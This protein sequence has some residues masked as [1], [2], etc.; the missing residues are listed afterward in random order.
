MTLKVTHE[1]LD[2]CTEI[3]RHSDHVV[4]LDPDLRTVE[5]I[6]DGDPRLAIYAELNRPLKG[7]RSI[8]VEAATLRV[9]DEAIVAFLYVNRSW[10]SDPLVQDDPLASFVLQSFA[11]N[12]QPVP[13]PQTEPYDAL[14]QSAVLVG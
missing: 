7:R 3:V 13:N 11:T 4:P 5:W 12:F 1:L 10:E 8:K 9:E 2:V 6:G 14:Y